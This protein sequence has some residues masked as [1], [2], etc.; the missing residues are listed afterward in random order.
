[1]EIKENNDSTNLLFF[2]FENIKMLSIITLIGAVI[3]IVA[4]LMIEN[5]YSAQVILY[6]SATNSISKA[7]LS[8][9]YGGKADLMEFG[10]EEQ[11][12]QLL[13]ILNSS[14]IRDSI[15]KKYDLM[16]HYEIEADEKHPRTLLFK[17][18]E[19]N[20]TFKRNEYMAVEIKVLDTDPVKAA[21]MANDVAYYLDRLK[22]KIHKKRAN[23]GYQIVANQYTKMK[24]EILEMEDS[25]K[26][27]MELGVMDVQSQTEVLNRTYAEAL[28]QKNF[29]AAAEIEKK[30]QVI[31]LHG[32]KHIA[33]SEMLENQRKQLTIIKSKYEEAKVDAEAEITTFFQ[34]DRAYVPEKKA[35]PVRW[36]IVVVSTIASF[37]LA[38]L[39]LII[40]SQ[41]KKFKA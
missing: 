39:M 14:E 28:I 18:Y 41:M 15:I 5:K 35:Y 20:F 23:Q 38:V 21:D 9:T 4:S 19:S 16:A 17:E 33:L 2:L 12:E 3:S 25:L 37:I 22:A 30:L 34:T 11:A 31:S 6:P 26:K 1:M 29:K 7:L 8:D 32:A 40:T 10:E 24:N 13:Q 36:L 27:I